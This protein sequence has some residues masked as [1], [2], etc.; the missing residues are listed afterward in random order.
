LKV[1]EGFKEGSCLDVF[2]EDKGRFDVSDNSSDIG[3]EMPRVS[4][5]LLFSSTGKWL[6]RESRSN[7]IHNATPRSAFEGMNIRP[8]RSLIHD[9]FLHTRNQNRGC[10]GFPL[11]ITDGSKRG[12]CKL[13]SKFE[14][15]NPGA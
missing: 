7:D 15:T 2:E 9:S 11:H 1:S 14:P 8:D 4:F 13:D 6:A 3:P 12:P 5:S 10:V